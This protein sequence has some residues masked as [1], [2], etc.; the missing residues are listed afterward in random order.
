[1]PNANKAP[2]PDRR[3]TTGPTNAHGEFPIIALRDPKALLL[4]WT[5]SRP[6]L[7]SRPRLTGVRSRE[8]DSADVK[9]G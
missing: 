1:M 5:I 8:A 6:F 4:K 2:I 9:V 3:A 7:T